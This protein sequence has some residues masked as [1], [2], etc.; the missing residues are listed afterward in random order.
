MPWSEI[1]SFIGGVVTALGAKPLIGMLKIRWQ[2]N[3]VNQSGASAKGDVVGRD[4]FGNK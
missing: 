4:K 1:L 3:K 2:S